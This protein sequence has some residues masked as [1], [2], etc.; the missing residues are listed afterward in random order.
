[1]PLSQIAA[2]AKS[3]DVILAADG[4]ANPLRAMNITPHI[5]LGDFDSIE[6]VPLDGIRLPDQNTSDFDKL[7][8]EA[9]ARS[10][11][12]LTVCNAEGD[13]PDHFL[14]SLYSA[15][16]S[17]VDVRF[18]FRRGLGHVLCGFVARDFSVPKG[19]RVSLLPLEECTGV[20]LGGVRWELENAVLKPR[21]LVSLSNV[22]ERD[23]I[24]VE[25]ATGACFLSL[26][27]PYFER[28]H[29]D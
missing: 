12:R 15:A 25:L 4:G 5:T 27:H 28:P 1:M 8:A 14:A 6:E 22:A 20:T 7:L 3:A 11:H 10:Y 19:A 18:A 24:H 21:G 17:E 16:R 26:L 23:S 9:D 2:W 13:L 29:W